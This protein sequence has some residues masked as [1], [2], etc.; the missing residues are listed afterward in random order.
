LF[1]AGTENEKQMGYGIALAEMAVE[2]SGLLSV[3]VK[4]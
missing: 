1:P 4:S 2:I 3:V